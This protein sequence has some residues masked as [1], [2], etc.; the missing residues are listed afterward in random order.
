MTSGDRMVS[1]FTQVSI[2]QFL[3]PKTFNIRAFYFNQVLNNLTPVGLDR[4]K[5]THVTVYR[6]EKSTDGCW[7][8]LTPVSALKGVLG[9]VFVHV[10][11]CVWWVRKRVCIYLCICVSVFV[12]VYLCVCWGEKEGWKAFTK[13]NRHTETA[14][15]GFN[16][17]KGKCLTLKCEIKSIKPWGEGVGSKD[18]YLF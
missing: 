15:L 14:P 1:D 16:D 12:R 6:F 17:Q 7:I 9:V 10:C 4:I 8:S 3:T 13:V 5:T 18:I 2:I 11:E